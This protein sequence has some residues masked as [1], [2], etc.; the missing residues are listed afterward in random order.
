MKKYPYQAHIK[1]GADKAGQ[2]NVTLDASKKV[3][4]LNVFSN[5]PGAKFDIAIVD[6]RGA[7]QY[8]KKGLTSQTDR[9]GARLD[10]PFTDNTYT[11]KVN[12]VEGADEI[13][14]FLE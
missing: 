11:I 6:S 3:A 13:N 14:A 10:L 2:D 12:N 5:K 1:I 7:V 4:W 9:Y 8:E